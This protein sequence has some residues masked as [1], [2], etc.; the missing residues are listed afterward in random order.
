MTIVIHVVQFLDCLSFSTVSGHPFFLMHA[1]SHLA[2]S[3][4]KVI[5]ILEIFDKK[6]DS[7]DIYHQLK[8]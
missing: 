6:F 7:Y 4:S 1:H 3:L 2:I 8:V 5:T